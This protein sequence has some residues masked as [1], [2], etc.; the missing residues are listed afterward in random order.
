MLIKLL[1]RF[2]I[3]LLVFGNFYLAN[4]SEDC[5][6]WMLSG[7][8][9]PGQENCPLKCTMLPTDMS[10]FSCSSNCDDLCKTSLP[11]FISDHILWP[12]NLT[13]ADKALIKKFPLDAFKGRNIILKSEKS[14]RRIFKGNYRNDESD[15]FRHFLGAGLLVDSIGE[16][17]ARRFLE[18]HESAPELPRDE[19]EMDIFNNNKGISKA[20][21]LIRK[22]IFSKKALEK[23]AL[24]LIKK[25]ELKIINKSGNTPKWVE[26][27]Y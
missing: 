9:L 3:I 27:K 5:I 2:L 17:Q 12:G 18:A 22:K 24:D 15:A 10:T 6:D 11:N 20:N 1:F 4:A 14:T 25:G 8:V 23:E 13:E 16:K 7:K 26:E 21:E 19:V